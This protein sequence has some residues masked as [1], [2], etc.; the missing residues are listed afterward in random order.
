M[1]TTTQAAAALHVSVRRVQAMIKSERL[2][3]T[4]VGRDWQIEPRSLAQ[5]RIRT[6]GRPRKLAK[7]AG[8]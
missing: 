4:K 5:V 6:N 1:L 7:G 2:A 3:A 8:Q